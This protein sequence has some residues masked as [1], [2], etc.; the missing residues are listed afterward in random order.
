MKIK[1]LDGLLGVLG[2]QTLYISMLLCFII[3]N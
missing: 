3:R 2:G 1:F